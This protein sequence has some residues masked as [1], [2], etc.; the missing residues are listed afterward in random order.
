MT[1]DDAVWNIVLAS[2]PLCDCGTRLIP[3]RAGDNH[4]VHCPDCSIVSIVDPQWVADL[5][6]EAYDTYERTISAQ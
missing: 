4:T 2:M 5:V 1:E 6:N 3:G